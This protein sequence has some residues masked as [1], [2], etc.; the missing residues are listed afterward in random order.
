MPTCLTS[1]IPC[2]GQGSE[3]ERGPVD[4]NNALAPP[5]DVIAAAAFVLLPLSIGCA[6]LVD[7]FCVD[8]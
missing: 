2:C 4:A 7:R 6:K 1:N 3:D 8:V 5:R